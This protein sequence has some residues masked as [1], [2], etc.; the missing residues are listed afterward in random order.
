MTERARRPEEA[1]EEAEKM[2]RRAIQPRAREAM[3]AREIEA[4]HRGPWATR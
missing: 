2:K 4:D 1:V 3:R